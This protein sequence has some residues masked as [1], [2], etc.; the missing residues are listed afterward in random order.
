[1]SVSFPWFPLHFLLGRTLQSPAL[2][3]GKPT[4]YLCSR[5]TSTS[6]PCFYPLPHY[7]LQPWLQSPESLHSDFFRV[8]IHGFLLGGERLA[9]LSPLPCPVVH[10][11]FLQFFHLPRVP[12]DGL[13]G[14]LLG[15]PLAGGYVG[16][17]LG[18]AT[19]V[20]STLSPFHLSH[21][22]WSYTCGLTSFYFHCFH[23]TA[24]EYP[25]VLNIAL[26]T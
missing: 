24:M 19:S 14:F 7:S 26:G 25:T 17:I 9:D 23:F 21:L 8:H 20:T 18:S 16:G 1:M 15:S 4:V 5:P 22:L 13:A 10:G 2:E 12:W 11:A 6:F 3:A